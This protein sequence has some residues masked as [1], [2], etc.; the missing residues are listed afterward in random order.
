MRRLAIL[1]IA[2]AAAPAV[3]AAPH[4]VAR[5]AAQP[6]EARVIARDTLWNC[7]EGECTA[8]EADSR[9]AIICSLLAKE[10]GALTSFAV[11]GRLLPASEL[12]KCNA[13]ARK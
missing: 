13:K 5:P 8:A 9:P 10:V 7:G 11:A 3:A 6:V 12:E 4:Y 2:L 1:S